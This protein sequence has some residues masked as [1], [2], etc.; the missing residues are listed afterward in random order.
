[1][2]V[3]VQLGTVACS[4]S[5]RLTPETQLIPGFPDHLDNIARPHLKTKTTKEYR[6]SRK[7]VKYKLLC[8]V[9]NSFFLELINFIQ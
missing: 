1:M 3:R 2:I 8:Q 9:K 6:C 5:P 4:R 7:K